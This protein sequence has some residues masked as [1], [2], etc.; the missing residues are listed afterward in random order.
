[1]REKQGF[2]AD[3][4]KTCILCSALTK[5]SLG[6]PWQQS[7]PDQKFMLSLGA[8]WLFQS[9]QLTPLTIW[10][11]WLTLD[12]MQ[13][14]ALQLYRF[15]PTKQGVPWALIYVMCNCFWIFYIADVFCNRYLGPIDCEAK[16]NTCKHIHGLTYITSTHK[17]QA[18]SFFPP[19]TRWIR[20]PI[21]YYYYTFPKE[22]I[23]NTISFRDFKW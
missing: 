10:A 5:G 23:Q 16:Q 13:L 21:N 9:L 7:S 8:S 12:P 17:A 2:L 6:R 3:I 15:R 18:T 22:E 20:N 19:L 1:M 14:L 11:V 4:S